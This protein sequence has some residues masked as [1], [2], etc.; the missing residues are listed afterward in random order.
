MKYMPVLTLCL[1]LP[2][3]HAQERTAAGA[4]D[5]QMTWSS[6][7]T[8]VD[9]ANTNIKAVHMRLDKAEEC[10]GKGMLYAPDAQDAEQGCKPVPTIP[11]NAV[12]AFHQDT[13]PAGWSEYTPARGRFLRGL[14]NG[15]GNDPSGNR[16]VGQVQEDA[17]QGHW[18][19]A[20]DVN[21]TAGVKG[22]NYVN[23]KFRYGRTES[24]VVK[25]P[26]SNGV[27]GTPRTAAETRPK[28]VAVLYCRKS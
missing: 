3:T 24:D 16:S 10:A 1:M 21:G 18:H 20:Y 27:H 23:V 17:F 19:G 26:I 22:G 9:S 7:K 25:D 6:L 28:N 13:C 15:A 8:L 14:D 2:A 11:A 12:M 4:L 5:T